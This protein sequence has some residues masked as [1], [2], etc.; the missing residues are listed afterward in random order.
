MEVVRWGVGGLPADCAGYGR[1]G[2]APHACRVVAGGCVGAFCIYCIVILRNINKNIVF[3]Q[4]NA[5]VERTAG[6]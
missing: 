3:S 4:P 5:A 6:R 1:A 2:A